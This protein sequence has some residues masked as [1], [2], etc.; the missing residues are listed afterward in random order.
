[1]RHDGGKLEMNI[2]ELQ[3][4]KWWE[5]M[6]RII[7]NVNLNNILIMRNNHIIFE[8]LN[9]YNGEFYKNLECNHIFKCCIEN[10]VYEDEE[11]AYFIADIYVKELSKDEVSSSLEYYKYGYNVNLAH[12]KKLYLISIIGNDICIDIICG[13]FSIT[14]PYK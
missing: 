4:N 8:L 12:V 1:M 9:S 14:T 7:E 6:E 11:F 2:F 5:H 10:E 13:N 3:R